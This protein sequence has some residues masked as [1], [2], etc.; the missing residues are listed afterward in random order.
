MA[1]K[2]ASFAELAINEA[3]GTDYRIIAVERPHSPVL[4][5]APHGGTIEVGT[6]EL[7]ISVAGEEHSLFSFEGLKPWGRNRDLHITSHCFDHP[8]C[9]E[10]V[11]RSSVTL[12]I[13]G[14]KGDSQIYVGGL[15]TELSELLT[16][17]LSEAG[18]PATTTG[19]RYL[20]RNPLNVCNRGRRQRG[21]QLELTLD[22][23]Q[24]YAR[25]LIKPVIRAALA[26]HVECLDWP[27]TPQPRAPIDKSRGPVM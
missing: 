7:A 13:H 12:G 3:H 21:A 5:V 15:D 19:H 25:E 26:E 16:R 9:L 1:D 24:R 11:A 27:A 10:L 2:Y 18:F 22:F 20:G 23:R 14:C 6:S 17:R 4:I 8:H